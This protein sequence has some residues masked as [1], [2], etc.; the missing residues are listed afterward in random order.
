MKLSEA[1]R[2]T[3]QGYQVLR[4][5]YRPRSDTWIIARCTLNG[6]WE[7]TGLGNYLTRFDAGRQIKTLAA[8][9]HKYIKY[10]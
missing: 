9:N 5:Q 8:S 2:L 10:T 1:I 6:G 7:N 3:G 4:P